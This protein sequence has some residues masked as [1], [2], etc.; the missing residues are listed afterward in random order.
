MSHIMFRILTLI[1][2]VLFVQAFAPATGVS[3]PLLQEGKKTLYQRVISHPKAKLYESA[4]T[5]SPVV[6]GNLRTFTPLYVYERGDGWLR[7]GVSS[8]RP[9]G[10]IQLDKTTAWNQSMTL[11]FT[12]KA[13]RDPVI[14]FK[15][16]ED[17]TAI[18]SADNMSEQLAAILK[19]V[20]ERN[21][22]PRVTAAEPQDS[23]VNADSFYLMPILNMQEVFEGTRFLEVASI[24]PGTDKGKV[25]KPKTGVAIVIDTTKSMGPYLERCK[26]L[27]KTVYDHLQSEGLNDNVAFAMV[28]FRNSVE[29]S[30]GIEY[31]TRVISD[32]VT[33]SKRADFEN[34]LQQLEEC[35]LST[36]SF[37]E[38]SLAGVYEAVQS[39]SWQDYTSR[40]ILLVTDASPLPYSD[41]WR[42]VNMEPQEM[43]DLAA[44][45]GIWIVALHLMTP[46]GKADHAGAQKAYLA[47][48]K[49][50]GKSQ[51]QAIKAANAATGA[52]NFLRIADTMAKSMAM[53]VKYTA[54]GR[55]MTRPKDEP[56]GQQESPEDMA[57]RLG[58]A[59]QLDY[60][61]RARKTGAPEVVNSWIA[62]MDLN[63]LA[64][65]R[66]VPNVEVAIMLT[67]AQLSDLRDQLGIIVDNAE[68]TK[69]TDSTDF[70]QGI[71]SASAR[72]SRDPGAPTAGQ[73][74][75]QLGV[76]G[77][78]LDGL[79]YRSEVMLLTEEDW[80]R[81]SVGQ[82]T[83][84]INRLKS[85]I[86]R[87]EEYDRENALWERFG[88]YNSMDWVFRMPLSMLP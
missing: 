73:N 33:A 65:S 40:M 53:M 88:M 42:A 58:Y 16:T 68:R 5:G 28:A 39:L 70:F 84:F 18:C 55:M 63:N 34:R 25:G 21:P 61:G 8:N 76:L 11:L 66:H 46:A 1:G 44:Q 72:T 22:D 43:N 24:D 6:N 41:R 87:Y 64:R 71:L 82:Q 51:Y 30:P 47:L 56:A 54:E 50:N 78:F 23:S 59:M 79:P 45:K 3:A 4:D 81:M 37:S 62:D 69:K 86:A 13:N 9:D 26:S 74:L 17:L 10:W 67:K 32:F 20:R 38:D 19:G 75:A 36:H 83:A 15:S 57:A 29:A 2:C 77:E 52:E 12:N 80:Y 48:S 49:M 60:F 14:F 35:Q 85:K 31:R 27:I 7:V